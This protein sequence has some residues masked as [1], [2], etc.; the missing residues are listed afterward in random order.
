MLRLAGDTGQMGAPGEGVG[1][2][3]P[4]LVRKGAGMTTPP[5]ANL[6][7]LVLG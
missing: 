4:C 3:A 5:L 2:R 1:E 6:A 7:F